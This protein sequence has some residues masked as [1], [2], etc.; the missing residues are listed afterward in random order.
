MEQLPEG[1]RGMSPVESTRL[2]RGDFPTHPLSKV[3]IC[4]VDRT[5][6]QVFHLAVD[7]V[8]ADAFVR[9]RAR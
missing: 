1:S 8:A 3:K 6:A 7:H 2:S 9:P 5:S 4:V